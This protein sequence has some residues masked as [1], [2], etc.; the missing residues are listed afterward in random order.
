MN[1]SVDY[2]TGEATPVY[3]SATGSVKLDN[4][5]LTF[6]N[7]GYLSLSEQNGMNSDEME[8]VTLKD[9]F[10]TP[11]ESQNGAAS[12]RTDA[13]KNF[14]NPLYINP[15]ESEDTPEDFNQV[16]LVVE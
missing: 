13:N 10:D 2:A 7:P 6:D 12:Q 8:P 1:D 5:T 4:D 16:R 15:Q 9:S 3:D 11:F 14:E